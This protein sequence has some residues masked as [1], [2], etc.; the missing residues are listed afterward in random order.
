M[1]INKG[2]FSL[3]TLT[4]GAKTGKGISVQT[5]KKLIK[6]YYHTTDVEIMQY[7]NTQLPNQV[8]H[9]KLH[10]LGKKKK[11]VSELR[12]WQGNVIHL[13][14]PKKFEVIENLC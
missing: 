8:I 9:L 11:N 2:F 7:I 14:P 5:N 10:I 6:I 12:A 4:V 3:K 1:P 13:I